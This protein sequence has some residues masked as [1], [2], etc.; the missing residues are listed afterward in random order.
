MNEISTALRIGVLGN[1]EVGSALVG[2]Y[3][4]KKPFIRDLSYDNFPERLDVLH[5]CTPWSEAFIGEVTTVLKEKS[6]SAT[7][8][9]STLPVGTT[10]MFG[11]SAVHSPVRGK[12]TDLLLS[13]RV[14]TKFL[15]YNELEI[16]TFAKRHLEELGVSVQLVH[17]TETTELLKLLDTTY[18]ATCIAFHAYAKRLCDEVGVDFDIV[19]RQANESYNE[20]YRRMGMGHVARPVLSPPTVKIGGHCLIP[21]AIHLFRQFGSNG[22]LDEVLR[23][24]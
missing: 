19:M 2:L 18:Y 5:V 15:G 17:G 4:D 13:L 21:N 8:I 9:H 11:R 23:L 12:H 6:P 10:R 3:G 16:G 1:G 20:G 22:I 14:F 24:R 7:I